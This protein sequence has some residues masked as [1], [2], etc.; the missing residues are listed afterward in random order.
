METG[1]VYVVTKSN[2]GGTFVAGDVFYKSLDGKYH[3]VTCDTVFD[4]DEIIGTKTLY[5]FQHMLNVFS[6]EIF[7]KNGKALI[8]IY[9]LAYSYNVTMT[10]FMK[11]EILK[12]PSDFA[13]VGDDFDDFVIDASAYN[14]LKINM[15]QF[16]RMFDYRF[17]ELTN[18]EIGD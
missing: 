12:Y 11:K 3:N 9:G 1:T 6:R 4:S 7:S 5:E 10:S 16:G 18:K 2:I 8:C 14:T 15:P 13:Y 17:I